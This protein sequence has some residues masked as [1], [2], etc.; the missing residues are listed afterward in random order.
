MAIATFKRKEIKFLI[1][2]EQ[3][4]ALIPAI[5]EHMVPDSYCVG[6]RSMVFIISITTLL[7]AI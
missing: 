7:T 1:N 5:E 6:G 4:E 2:D 3:F